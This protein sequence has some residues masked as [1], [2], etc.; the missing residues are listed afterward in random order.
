M[1]NK[2]VTNLSMQGIFLVINASLALSNVPP[3]VLNFFSTQLPV[4]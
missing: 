4:K 3:L 2:G 1:H